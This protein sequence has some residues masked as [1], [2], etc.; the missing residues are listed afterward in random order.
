MDGQSVS[1]MPKYR[2]HKT[3][4][5]LKIKEVGE[6]QLGTVKLTFED[7]RYAPKWVAVTN[8]PKPEAGWFYVVY[9]NDYHSFSPAQAFEDGYTLEPLTFQDRVRAEK[10]NLS[11]KLDKLETFHDSSTFS[12]LS[13]EEQSR[14]ARQLLIMQLYEQVL[15]ERIANF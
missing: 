6:E 4:W 14:L 12:S 7:E 13:P 11:E 15:A 1:E 8:R 5:A 2:S 10:N 3:V 9:D